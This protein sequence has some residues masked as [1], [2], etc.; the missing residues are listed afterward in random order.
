MNHVFRSKNVFTSKEK[1]FG[2]ISVKI[3][4]YHVNHASRKI[5]GIPQILQRQHWCKNPFCT[6]L[7]KTD[8]RIH[9]KGV[10]FM[11]RGIRGNKFDVSLEA[12]NI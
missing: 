6:L 7:M 5:P 12:S 2:K 3:L 4:K 8:A 11:Y 9:S 1:H 10:L